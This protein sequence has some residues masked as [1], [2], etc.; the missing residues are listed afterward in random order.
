MLQLRNVRRSQAG[1]F[2]AAT[3]LAL[4]AASFPTSG[5]AQ[6][7]SSAGTGAAQVGRAGAA[8]PV[9]ATVPRPETYRATIDRYCATC[10]NDRLK[11][12]NL[13]LQGLDLAHVGEQAE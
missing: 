3:T 9:G 4:A 2:V 1:A 12:A 10:H 5:A 13:S 7:T 8:S 6:K 11:T